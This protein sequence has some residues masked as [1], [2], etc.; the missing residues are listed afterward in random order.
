MPTQFTVLLNCEEN[1]IR[2]K[3][4]KISKSKIIFNI[5]EISKRKFIFEEL[6]TGI[7]FCATFLMF[8]VRSRQR[9][10]GKATE[11]TRCRRGVVRE[12]D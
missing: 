12:C 3:M 9:L 4:K 1:T 10:N 11:C 8:A 5:I 6:L 2:H 7:S